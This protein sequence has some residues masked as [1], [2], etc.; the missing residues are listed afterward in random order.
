MMAKK[1][2]FIMFNLI[3]A[4]I[5][6]NCYFQL[7]LKLTG[8]VDGIDVVRVMATEHKCTEVVVLEQVEWVVNHQ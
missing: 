4:E 8:L 2:T 5:E 1:I 6:L 3:I 7:A